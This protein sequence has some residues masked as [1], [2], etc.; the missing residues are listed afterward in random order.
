MAGLGA[1]TLPDPRAQLEKL[2]RDPLYQQMFGERG[3]ALSEDHR[4]LMLEVIDSM[5]E[6]DLDRWLK[7]LGQETSG[8]VFQKRER[9]KLVL[10]LEKKPEL[11]KSQGPSRISIENANEGEYIQGDD[12]KQGLLTLRGRIR[13]R[14]PNG[15]VYANTVI[16]DT[17]R[18]EIYAEGDLLYRSSESEI[19]A[20]RMLFDQ[21][22]GTGILYNANGYTNPVFF[23]G[24]SLQVFN[25]E[26]LSIQHAYFTSCAQEV[27]HYSFTA[28]RLWLYENRKIV[29]VG[30][31]YYVGPVPLLPLPF[32]YASDWGTGIITQ[33]GHGDVQGSFVNLTYQFTLPNAYFYPFVPTHYRVKAD[34]YQNTGNAVGLEMYR[35]SPEVNYI[36]D[37]GGAEAKRYELISDYREKDKLR[38][39]NR[40]LRDDGTYGVE[41]DKWYKAF[42]LLNYKAQERSSN[43][44][45]NVFI[46]YE[47]YSHRLYEFEFGGRY[48]PVTT[49]PALYENSEAGRGIIRNNLNWNIVYNEQWDTLSVRVEGA[50]D[51]IWQEASSFED[52][53]YVPLSDVVPSVDVKK[54]FRLG[55][56]PGL[57][58]PIYWD[59]AIHSDLKKEYTL[60]EVFKTT[61]LNLFTS[62]V[63]S[64]FSFFPYITFQPSIGYGAQKTTP[65]A[66]DHTTD[67]FIAQDRDAQKR[68]YQFY[69]SED[70]L[71]IGPHF[72]FLRGTY[73]R[74]DSFKEELKDVSTINTRGFTNSQKINETEVALET[75]PID[76]MS[77]SITSIYDHRQF[78]YDVK[79]K[80]RW[81]YPVFR[82]DI[83]LDFLGFFRPSRENLLSRQK[84]H[85]MGLRLTNDY[86][87]NAQLKRDHSNV[88]GMSWAMGGFDLYVLRRLRYLE[89]GYYW[90]HVYYNQK[91]DHMRYFAKLDLQIYKWVFFEMEMES[92]ATEIERYSKD[93]V[94][95]NGDSDYIPFERDL[96]NGTGI[97]GAEK[98]Q[99]SV[100]NVAYFEAAMLF[101]LHDWEMRFG[102]SVEQ[103]TILAG[104]NSLDVV[105]FYDNRVFLSMTLLRFDVGRASDRPSRFTLH[106]DRVRPSD[107]GRSS[108]ELSR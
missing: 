73:R 58:A 10:S 9:L 19:R 83:Y 97:N 101:E 18:Q 78:D 86:V 89:M 43:H 37:V 50:R 91:L 27:P 79:N 88:F 84:R 94:D 16:I 34:A 47:D 33:I 45:R 72:L 25:M 68:S 103:K 20:E 75:Y 71:T 55:E 76:N 74:K 98:R 15:S 32:L 6:K 11:P 104:I 80:D 30:V 2:Q 17:K 70:E 14:L 22:L 3:T 100:F 67:D 4:K 65:Y 23:F 26:K 95:D 62:S 52:S 35:F 99:N 106:R 66:K 8:S 1:Q 107:L 38:V 61:N 63:R 85:F 24:Q 39:T 31:L 42:L 12:S 87:Y 96:V 82:S 7:D 81:Y 21:K 102:Y 56:I 69:F 77:F 36:L 44:N 46:R 57:D 5:A 93:S 48:T 92:R 51:R 105:N 59:N 40:V 90:Y 53:R 41:K 54:K 29:A 64:Y 49:I 13:L 28:R 108:L 60:G